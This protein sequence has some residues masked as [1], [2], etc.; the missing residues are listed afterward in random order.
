M[1]HEILYLES[2]VKCPSLP[3]QRRPTIIINDYYS[4]FTSE[5]NNL[6]MVRCPAK[7]SL[8]NNLFFY[9]FRIWFNLQKL[10]VFAFYEYTL[11]NADYI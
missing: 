8:Q 4:H 11:F 3:T 7:F 5:I 1:E 10:P 2:Y 6:G 9:I